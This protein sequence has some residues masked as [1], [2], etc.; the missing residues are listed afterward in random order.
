MFQIISLIVIAAL[1]AIDQFTKYLIVTSA[2]VNGP[3]ELIPNVIQFRYVENTGAAFSSFSDN[4]FVLT[5][6]TVLIIL[7][8]LVFLWSRKINSGFAEACLI[9][10]LAG[11]IGNIID[12][13]VFGYVVDFIEPLFVDFAVFNFAD[14][15]ITI[16]AF[17]LIGYEIY[18]L[19]KGRNQKDKQD[20]T[21]D[22]RN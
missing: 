16:G 19:I 6:V 8:C 14:C 20:D 15:C 5:V 11:G 1:A 4:T 18:D 21:T 12:R 9:L 3:L 7:A 10:V 22:F 2:K 17:M 13:I